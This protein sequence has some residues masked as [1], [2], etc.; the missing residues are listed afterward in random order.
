MTFP[1]LIF[2]LF[3][4]FFHKVINRDYKFYIRLL[5]CCLPILN[6]LLLLYTKINLSLIHVF[7]W[8]IT[9]LSF[10]RYPIYNYS[11]DN[12]SLFKVFFYTFPLYM[13]LTKS[14]EAIFLI[15]FYNY[16]QIWIKIKRKRNNETDKFNLID[17]F[18][19]AFLIYSSFF[20]IGGI[21]NR[22]CSFNT[23]IQP[24]NHKNLATFLEAYKIAVPMLLVTVSFFEICKLSNYS[25]LD[26]FFI[27]FALLE[28]MNL[29]FFFELKNTGMTW[30]ELGMS[31]AYYIISICVSYIQLILFIISFFITR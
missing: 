28:V 13:L 4:N 21:D 25:Y 12:N 8:V 29:K 1:F 14:Y 16:L 9:I 24:W 31:I 15:I 3:T 20:S 7:S 23:F 17:I 10:C 22:N 2:T 5:Y 11:R 26:S 6:D 19:Y 18:I 30:K 27:L